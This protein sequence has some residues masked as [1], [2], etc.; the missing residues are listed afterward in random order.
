MTAHQQLEQGKKT[1]GWMIVV[2]GCVY[3]HCHPGTRWTGRHVFHARPQTWV[4]EYRM[5]FGISSSCAWGEGRW[6]AKCLELLLRVFDYLPSRDRSVFF[7][8]FPTN[9]GNSGAPG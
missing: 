3:G 7:F 9:S 6:L 1:S 8:C 5:T 4:R 2:S